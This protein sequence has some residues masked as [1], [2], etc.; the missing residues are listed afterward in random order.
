MVAS[1]QEKW[2]ALVKLVEAARQDEAENERL[3]RRAAEVRCLFVVY[4]RCRS[5]VLNFIYFTTHH[6]FTP[7]VQVKLR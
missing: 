5:L 7:F 3:R 6:R 4:Q 2:N 1:V